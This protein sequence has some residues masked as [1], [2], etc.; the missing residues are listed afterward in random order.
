MAK[1]PIAK[2][3]LSSCQPS[4]L[5]EGERPSVSVMLCPDLKKP[6]TAQFDYPAASAVG[7]PS[8]LAKLGE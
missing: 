4:M 6:G 2:R 1:L 7:C 3:D 5:S 8:S